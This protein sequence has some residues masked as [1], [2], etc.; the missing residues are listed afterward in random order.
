MYKATA[1][2]INAVRGSHTIAVFADVIQGDQS[3]YSFNVIG[4]S[5]TANAGDSIRRECTVDLVDPEGELAPTDVTDLLMPFGTEILLRRGVQFPDGTVEAVPWGVYRLDSFDASETDSGMTISI[6][7]YDRAFFVQ[8]SSS[9]SVVI[10]AGMD[11]HEAIAK[12]VAS[13]LITDTR[14]QDTG[15]VS[16]T[17]LLKAGIDVWE[18]AR[19]AAKSVGCEVFFDVT[20][21]LTMQSLAYDTSYIARFTNEDA[22]VFSITRT[23]Q[24]DGLPNGII[25]IGENSSL[26]RPVRGEAWDVN[27]KSPTYRYGTYGEITRTETSEYVISDA[28]AQSAAQGILER[29]LG[30]YETVKIETIP[31]PAQDVNDVVYVVNEKTGVDGYYVITDI[32]M[33]LDAETA[34]TITA[35]KRIIT[36]E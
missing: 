24:A 4:G 36:D 26:S 10:R 9:K 33:P 16:P 30:P 13:R 31:N 28:Q 5:A 8:Q 17:L 20:G 2:F 23:I 18:E 19:L 32:D 6:G 25:V 15:Y 29:E 27:P 34:M 22:N 21:A 1:N 14:M 7:G 35:R 12:M 11:Y 3:L